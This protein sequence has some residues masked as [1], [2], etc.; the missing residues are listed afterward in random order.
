MIIEKAKRRCYCRWAN[1]KNKQI[2]KAEERVNCRH[3]YYGYAHPICAV[4]IL[5]DK[6]NNYTQ[7]KKDFI[8]KYGL[9]LFAEEL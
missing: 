8:E 7:L 1:C 9:K 6:I 5:N 2:D 4:E 3:F